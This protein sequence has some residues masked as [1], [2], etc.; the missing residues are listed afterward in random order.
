MYSRYDDRQSLSIWELP[1]HQ[2]EG[3][4]ALLG[5]AF[6]AWLVNLVVERGLIGAVKAIAQ[7]VGAALGV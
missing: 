6:F 7:V 5:L 3:L 1:P 2:I 4:M